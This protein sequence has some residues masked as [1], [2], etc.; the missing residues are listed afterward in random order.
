MELVPSKARRAHRLSDRALAR[1][2][3]SAA[4]DVVD[5]LANCTLLG[6]PIDFDDED[7]VLLAAYYLGKRDLIDRAF[8]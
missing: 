5:V 1:A 6:E 8:E 3:G 7:S 2:M 4:A